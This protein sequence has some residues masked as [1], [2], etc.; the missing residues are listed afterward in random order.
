MNG[1][2]KCLNP[3]R[4]WKLSLE[5]ETS[6]CIVY[7][8]NHPFRASILLRGVW[9]RKSKIDP[10]GREIFMK[11]SII[12]LG[13]IITLKRFYG[14]GELIFDEGREVKKLGEDLIFG[15]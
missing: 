9:T 12:V 2:V 15:S 8:S 11:L 5:Q 6:N 10:I 7:S 4:V 1:R 13:P 14:C 3:I